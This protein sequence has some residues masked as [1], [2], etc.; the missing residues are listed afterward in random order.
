MASINLREALNALSE[1]ITNRP[2]ALREFDQIYMKAGDMILQTEHISRIFDK[3]DIVLIGDGDAIGLS[4]AHL[5]SLGILSSGPNSILLLDFDDRI[6]SSVN[7]FAKK[8]GIEKKSKLSYTMLLKHC[9]KI[10]GK[11]LMGFILTPHTGLVMRGGVLRR[12]L[13][14]VLKHARRML[15]LV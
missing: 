7:R 2:V 14:E 3:K 10:C 4:L 9:P 6:V 8:Y 15:L 13:S 1:V 11:N 5:H 12:L